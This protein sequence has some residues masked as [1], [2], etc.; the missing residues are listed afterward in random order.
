V[1]VVRHGLIG[2]RDIVS[3]SAS[4]GTEITT[5]GRGG[6]EHKDLQR[7]IAAWGSEHGFRATIERQ[8]EGGR[9]DVALERLG[10]GSPARLVHDPCGI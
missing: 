4:V 1:E 7:R 3:T 10:F 5:R 2:T 6:P 8:V 9:V